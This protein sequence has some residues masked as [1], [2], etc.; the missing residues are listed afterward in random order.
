MT[1]EMLRY[2]IPFETGLYRATI[3][4]IILD[5]GTRNTAD[6]FTKHNP[7]T[8]HNLKR[9]NYILKEDKSVSSNHS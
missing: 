9:H 6:Y 2:E 7:P 8:H 1:I 4:Y 5:K 3:I